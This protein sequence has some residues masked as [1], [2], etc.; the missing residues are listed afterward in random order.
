[1]NSPFPQSFDPSVFPP[2]GKHKK[3]CPVCSSIFRISYNLFHGQPI[4]RP[5]GGAVF[6]RFVIRIRQLHGRYMKFARSSGFPL[7]LYDIAERSG[8][9]YAAHIA[10]ASHVNIHSAR[11]RSLFENR[12]DV[13]WPSFFKSVPS[14]AD[15]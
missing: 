4:R 8:T 3:G 10:D 1:M 2:E 13:C 5:W 11:L 15:Y 14:L 12:N 7:E 6:D 9:V